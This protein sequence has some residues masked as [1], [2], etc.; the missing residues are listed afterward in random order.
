M[1]GNTIV[2]F[3]NEASGSTPEPSGENLLTYTYNDA[4]RLAEFDL[5]WTVTETN[6]VKIEGQFDQG[7]AATFDLRPSDEPTIT[8]KSNTSY[9]LEVKYIEGENPPDRNVEL[10]AQVNL[11]DGGSS[12]TYWANCNAAAYF[13]TGSG[14]AY[15]SD[16]HFYIEETVQ[17]QSR[18][19]DIYQ[20]ILREALISDKM[21]KVPGA[22]L[23]NF[24]SFN[25]YGNVKDSG[26]N[27][28]SFLTP[29]STIAANKI[30][31]GTFAND[32]KAKNGADGTLSTSM[33]RNIAAG[34]ADLTPGTSQL[35]TGSIYIVYE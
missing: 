10:F 30:G 34:D 23:N 29:S 22:A 15:I 8:L 18:D 11:G 14:E 20:P 27:A 13:T 3:A 33:L 6:A 35:T 1:I 21:D 25:E 12:T 2:D 9:A 24:A 7:D 26:K 19:G 4:P 16:I 32:I 5:I 28:S 17:F 31:A